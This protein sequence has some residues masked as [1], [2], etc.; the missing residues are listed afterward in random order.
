M[1][2]YQAEQQIREFAGDRPRGGQ[3]EKIAQ[4]H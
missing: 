2:F 1:K 4:N 3:V